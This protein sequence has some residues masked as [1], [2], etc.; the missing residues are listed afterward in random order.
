MQGSFIHIEK[1]LSKFHSF[2]RMEEKMK[3]EKL[4]GYPDK[5]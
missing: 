2:G 3:G 1:N 5:R 4:V